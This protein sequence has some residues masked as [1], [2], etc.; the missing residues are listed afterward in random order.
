[1][2]VFIMINSGQY[3]E[4]H[5][6]AQCKYK[7]GNNKNKVNEMREFLNTAKRKTN[8]HV[9]FLVTNV[10]LENHAINELQTFKE[11]NNNYNNRICI[12]FIQEFK[13]KVH[14]YKV[15]IKHKRIKLE[16]EKDKKIEKKL[17]ELE[18]KLDIILEYLN[19][20]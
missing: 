16:K 7:S 9:A 17:S 11:N 12:C 15:I 18:K 19:R 6:F 4:L 13:K 5:W 2:S 20:K 10:E 3:K 1:M 8:Y 14:K